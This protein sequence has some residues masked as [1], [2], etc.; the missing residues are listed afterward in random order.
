MGYTILH[1]YKSRGI[2]HNELFNRLRHR[3]HLVQLSYMQQLG[4][5]SLLDASWVFRQLVASPMCVQQLVLVNRIS[6]DR[7]L[8]VGVHAV[9]V[10]IGGQCLIAVVCVGV[11][12]HRECMSMFIGVWSLRSVYGV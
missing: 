1:R 12:D 10:C 5:S 9:L 3:F 4:V 2:G 7:W 8:C 11:H 6:A